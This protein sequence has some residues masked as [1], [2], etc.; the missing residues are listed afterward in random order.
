MAKNAV[1]RLKIVPIP[2]TLPCLS[3]LVLQLFILAFQFLDF[4]SAL[5]QS[6][7]V[8][9][10]THLPCNLHI[11]I[12]VAVGPFQL[13]LNPVIS[14]DI[15]Q[16]QGLFF[17]PCTTTATGHFCNANSIR[18]QIERIGL[19]TAMGSIYSIGTAELFRNSRALYCGGV[20]VYI[21]RACSVR[22]PCRA[23]PCCTVALSGPARYGSARDGTRSHVDFSVPCRTEPCQNRARSPV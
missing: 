5:L 21:A 17:V 8:A 4:V 22:F 18:L 12:S 16:P 13:S 2:P 6:S 10:F 23:V 1:H 20:S 11:H 15:N 14:P 19:C 3:T 9:S 7:L